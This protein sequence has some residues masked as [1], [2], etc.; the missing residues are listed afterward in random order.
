MVKGLP[1]APGDEFSKYSAL[2][3]T[4]SNSLRDSL[5]DHKKW[6]GANN[7]LAPSFYAAAAHSA[8][9]RGEVEREAAAAK[10]FVNRTNMLHNPLGL[11][12]YAKALVRAPE[13]SVFGKH[14][15]TSMIRRAQFDDATTSTIDQREKDNAIKLYTQLA[16]RQD[17][18]HGS[19][20]WSLIDDKMT[21]HRQGMG[22]GPSLT[23]KGFEA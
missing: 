2:F 18:P 10:D 6:N 20:L 23:P 22:G 19:R 11:Y 12:E 4:K 1:N 21:E 5:F 14:V 15:V 13:A 7:F 16:A 8:R 17:I 3:D 9:H